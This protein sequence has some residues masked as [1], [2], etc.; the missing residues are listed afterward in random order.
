MGLFTSDSRDIAEVFQIHPLA[1]N[2]LLHTRFTN[3]NKPTTSQ[4]DTEL[5]CPS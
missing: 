4:K 3:A 2:M 1:V 5:T